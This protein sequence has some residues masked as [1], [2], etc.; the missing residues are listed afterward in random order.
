M[1][2]SK[3]HKLMKKRTKYV[4]GLMSGTSADGIDTALV[5]IKESEQGIKIKLIAFDCLKYSPRIKN[6]ILDCSQEN[7][8][9]VKDI[10]RLNFL[11]GE[12]FA[13]AA[14]H[15]VKK[16]KMKLENIDLIGSHGQTI[17]HLPDKEKISGVEISSTL[18]V[19]EA[20]IIAEKTG[21]VT[22]SDFRPRD[23]AAGGEGAPLSA[24]VD[25]ILYHSQQEGIIALNIGGIANV[26]AI[27][28]KAKEEDI[29]A[30]DTGPGNMLID[31]LIKRVSGGNEVCDR[32]GVTAQQ[33]EVVE[34]VLARLMEHPFLSKSPPKSTGREEFGEDYL[35]WIITIAKGINWKDLICTITAFTAKSIASACKDFI[36]P[37]A[38]FTKMI[39][40]GGGVHNKCLMNMLR[41]ELPQIQIVSSD[42]LKIPADAREAISFAVLA[43]ETIM[44][45]PGNLP[46]ATG[47][48]KKVVLGKIT[49]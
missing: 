41:E 5:R 15:I 26:T 46:S 20:S 42:E 35:N 18:Q 9:T 25:F 6:F 12:L 16:A 36:F 8:A 34:E 28:A 10:C 44:Q 43:N 49:L 3:L 14:C 45:R 23:M 37:V 19:G 11:L 7:T 27:P 31:G 21:I 13:Q 17:C 32:N 38:P 48:Q 1:T 2:E 33:G 47:A 40:S 24:Y 22:V 30:F 4:I 39:V 29:L